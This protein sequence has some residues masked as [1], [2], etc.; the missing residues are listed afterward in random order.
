MRYAQD[1][2]EETEGR[3]ARRMLRAWEPGWS[4]T[5]G[6]AAVLWVRERAAG[7]ARKEIFLVFFSPVP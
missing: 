3:R 6:G 4:G 7:R 5:K 2:D 1:R